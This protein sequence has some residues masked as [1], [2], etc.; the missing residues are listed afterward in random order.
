MQ[1]MFIFGGL[2]IVCNFLIF[3]T[4]NK[5]DAT[6]LFASSDKAIASN[7]VH[8]ETVDLA[9]VLQMRQN[10]QVIIVDVREATFYV[11]GHIQGAINLPLE[12]I[13]ISPTSLIDNLKGKS[14]VIVYC[15]GISCGRA[16]EAAR[17]LMKRGVRDV[18]IYPGGWP[19]WKSSNLPIDSPKT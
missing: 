17:D 8:F 1:K 6:S 3:I 12:D 10:P 14:A 4:Q 9:E 7:T 19:E 13:D 11:Y 16:Y 2:V 18:K 5:I 15:N